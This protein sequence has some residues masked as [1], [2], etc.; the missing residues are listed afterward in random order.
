MAAAAPAPSASSPNVTGG[1]G[2]QVWVNTKS[3]AIWQPGSRYYGKT[4]EGKYMTEKDALAEGDHA[5]ETKSKAA[6]AA[7]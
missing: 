3:G 5:H 2:G 1:G 6:P 4:K 7:N